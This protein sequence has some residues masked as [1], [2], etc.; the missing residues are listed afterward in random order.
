MKKKFPKILPILQL[1]KNSLEFQSKI[2]PMS[3][4]QN[5]LQKLLVTM[6]QFSEKLWQRSVAK[7]FPLTLPCEHI[8]ELKKPTTR[9]IHEGNLG[10]S[11]FPWGQTSS[12][13]N[14]AHVQ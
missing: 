13:E 14:T 11:P 9:S 6:K 4:Q 10:P 3:L 5:E 12:D 1:M 7:D 2:P 8:E